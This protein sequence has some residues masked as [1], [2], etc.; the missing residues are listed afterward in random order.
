MKVNPVIP[1]LLRTGDILRAFS[2]NKTLGDGFDFTDRILE[3]MQKAEADNPWFTGRFIR[4]SLRVWGESLTRASIDRWLAP[5]PGISTIESGRKVKVA[6]IM[7]GNIPLAGMHDFICCLLAGHRVIA[8]M[9]SDDAVLLPLIGDMLVESEPSLK[10]RMYF[11]T[12]QIHGFDAVIAT[13]SDNTARYFNYYFNR[14][15]HIIR[16]N[17][18]SIAVLD[19]RESFSNLDELCNDIF[20]YFG[21][22]C[23][24]VS[25]LYVPVG[26][27]F[28]N[29]TILFDA[30]DE[31]GNHFRYR[32]NYDYQKSILLINRTPFIDHRN[33]ILVRNP[34]LQSPLAVLHYEEY[35]DIG[36]VVSFMQENRDDLQCVVCNSDFF[37]DTVP[38][39][40]AQEPALWDY[41]DGVDTL[42][43]LLSL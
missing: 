1:A 9:S 20:D 21:M 16:K 13:G 15:P 18:N 25:K 23:R 42:A 5:Y 33:L 34:S 36:E 11:S 14:L 41:A 27:D 39:G 31:T 37:G 7:P 38:F 4:K 10:T 6:V 17:R 8:R 24:S 19:N 30:F 43:F 28:T 12:G 2:Q 22:G 35:E 3:R 29:F 32:N 26:Y 40:K